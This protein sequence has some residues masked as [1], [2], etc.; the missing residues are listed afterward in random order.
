MTGPSVKN[1]Y[2]EQSNHNVI[3]PFGN[4]FAIEDPIIIVVEPRARMVE[5]MTPHHQ[6][7]HKSEIQKLRF[8]HNVVGEDIDFKMV[9]ELCFYHN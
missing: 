6:M 1:P 2:C 5:Y 8:Y 7:R 9:K 4:G 3:I